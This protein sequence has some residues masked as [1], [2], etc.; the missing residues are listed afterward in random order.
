M[1]FCSQCQ[2]QPAPLSGKGFV[3]SPV[4]EETLAGTS[5]ASK[6]LPRSLP[7]S[8][9]KL[10]NTM[11]RV[12]CSWSSYNTHQS[13]S[14]SVPGS[15][16]S[17]TPRPPPFHQP[18]KKGGIKFIL[19]PGLAKTAKTHLLIARCASSLST[20]SQG[21]KWKPV[22]LFTHLS[23]RILRMKPGAYWSVDPLKQESKICGHEAGEGSKESLGVLL[24]E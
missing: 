3:Q 10:L 14:C 2:P 6:P 23:P 17:P 21:Y 11:P 15:G 4:P 8:P 1:G 22:I 12:F 19:I 7:C 16:C 24:E 20:W 5:D 9:S 13:L 18:T